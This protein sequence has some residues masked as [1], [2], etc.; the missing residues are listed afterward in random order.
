MLKFYKILNWVLIINTLLVYPIAEAL[1]YLSVP[2]GMTWLRRGQRRYTT[3]KFPS[4]IWSTSR[5]TT[6]DIGGRQISTRRTWIIN[7][8]IWHI[9]VFNMVLRP[10][11]RSRSRTSWNIRC[12]RTVRCTTRSPSARWSIPW[13]AYF[14]LFRIRTVFRFRNLNNWLKRSLPWSSSRFNGF[15]RQNIFDRTG[16]K[17][18]WKR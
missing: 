7:R 12:M 18:S 1:G 9:T 15:R 11:S 2:S 6:L 5:T 13:D 17:I 14:L 16:S 4:T 3:T 10:E 8:N